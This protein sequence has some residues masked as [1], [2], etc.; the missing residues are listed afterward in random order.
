MSV[1][2]DYS[3]EAMH[4]GLNGELLNA[5]LSHMPSDQVKMTFKEC[6]KPVLIFPAEQSDDVEN[7]ALLMPVFIAE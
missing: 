1:E 2:C 6:C 5:I 3:G 4:I 7:T